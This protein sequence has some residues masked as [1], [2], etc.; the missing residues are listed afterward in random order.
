V[1]NLSDIS[2]IS[3]E[4]TTQNNFSYYIPTKPSIK[5]ELNV[6]LNSKNIYD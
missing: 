6:L 5:M 4:E 1:S 3:I 2:K